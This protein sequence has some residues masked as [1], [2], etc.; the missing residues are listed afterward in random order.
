MINDT[1]GSG[2]NDIA[3][4]PRWEE[5]ALPLFEILKL[6]IE[7]WADS[8]ALVE[9]SEKIDNDLAA[10]VVIDNLEFTDVTTVHHNLEELNDNLASWADKN[11]PLAPAF[12]VGDCLESVSEN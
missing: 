3:E 9:P 10:S 11:L 2:E 8:N 6:D 1:L 12:C 4:L 7:P 5:L